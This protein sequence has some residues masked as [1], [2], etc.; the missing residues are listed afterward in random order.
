MYV[1]CAAGANIPWKTLF[2]HRTL[3]TKMLKLITLAHWATVTPI[4]KTKNI[5]RH[6]G[7][8]YLSITVGVL[9]QKWNV[10]RYRNL[11][12]YLVRLFELFDFWSNRKS[13]ISTKY[14]CKFNLSWTK[15]YPF[16]QP[17]KDDIYAFYC[18]VCPEKKKC[19]HQAMGD[20]RHHIDG[21]EHKNFTQNL[22]NQP[23]IQ[24]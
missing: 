12:N 19:K 16:L 24:G 5:F 14:G 23:K 20:V 4:R 11:W 15:K 2:K 10:K 1:W 18:T 17:A 22:Q 7:C 3:E 21:Q 13:E 9:L 6:Q 8:L